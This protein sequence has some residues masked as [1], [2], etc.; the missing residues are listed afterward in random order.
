MTPAAEYRDLLA[1]YDAVA[2]R[3]EAPSAGLLEPVLV[4]SGWSV[5]QH[6]YH[7]FR[8]NGSMLKAIRRLA[9][10]SPP[11]PDG[12]GPNRLGRLV[13]ERGQFLRG[14]AQAPE[15][16]RPPS[17]IDVDMLRRSLELNQHAT[18]KV[19]PLLPTLGSVPGRLPH[20]ILGP[21]NAAEWLRVIRV[22]SEHHLAIIRDIE[23]AQADE[24]APDA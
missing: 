16:V 6:L 20:P 10:A 17:E 3:L 23:T 21:L 12:E 2:G 18:A 11:L 8:A 4:V 5:G 13:L 1:F 19:E 22:H 7:I 24:T 9:T 15:Q 14:R